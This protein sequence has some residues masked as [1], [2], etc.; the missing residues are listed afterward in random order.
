[1][2]QYWVC[3]NIIIVVLYLGN[4]IALEADIFPNTPYFL[5][6]QQAIHPYLTHSE[7][8]LKYGANIV[9]FLKWILSLFSIPVL[10]STMK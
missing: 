2:K 5:Q 8:D 4:K 1:M 10:S 9:P 3:K 6:Q 7:Y